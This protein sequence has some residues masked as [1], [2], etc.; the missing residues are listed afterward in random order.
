MAATKIV[1]IYP[2]PENVQSFEAVQDL[3]RR[4]SDGP[5]RRGTG[6]PPPAGV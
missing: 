6:D 5:H 4:P 3:E 1:A 2:T